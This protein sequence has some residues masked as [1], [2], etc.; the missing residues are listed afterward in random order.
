MLTSVQKCSVWFRDNR[1]SYLKNADKKKPKHDLLCKDNPKTIK[2]C[3]DRFAL[4]CSTGR[5]FGLITHLR[6]RTETHSSDVTSR[7]SHGTS[8]KMKPDDETD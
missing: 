2:R 8:F 5:D 1:F 4:V 6:L 7:A 3:G